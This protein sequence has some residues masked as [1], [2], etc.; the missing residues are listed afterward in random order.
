[1]WALERYWLTVSLAVHRGLLYLLGQDHR[2]DHHM[3]ALERYWPTFRL[4]FI[5]GFSMDWSTFDCLGLGVGFV[6]IE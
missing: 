5:E 1:M 6:L 3:G 4:L 2:F